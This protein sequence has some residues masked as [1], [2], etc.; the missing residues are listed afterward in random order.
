MT[1][2]IGLSDLGS[3]LL[4]SALYGKGFIFF[5][6]LHRSLKQRVSQTIDLVLV[7]RLRPFKQKH[8]MVGKRTSHIDAGSNQ[9]QI[10]FAFFDFGLLRWLHG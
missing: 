6:T 2:I 5:Y 10:L 8:E 1:N 9:L 7:L 4:I 3:H